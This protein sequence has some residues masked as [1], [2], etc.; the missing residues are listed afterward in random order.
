[1]SLIFLVQADLNEQQRERFVSSMNIRQIAMPQY[2]YLQV[3]QLFLELFAVS[4][5]GVAD[6]NITHRK[7]STFYVI[8]EGETE[9]GEYGF[10]VLDEETGEEGFTGLYTENEFWVLGAKG[11]Y[12]KRRIYGRSFKKG[13]PKGYGKKGGKRSRPGFRPRSKGKGYAAWEDDQQDTAFWGKGKGKGKKGKKGMKGKDSFEGMPSWKGKGKGDGKSKGGKPFQQQQPPQANIAQTTSS[14]ASQAP[15]KQETAHAEESWSYDYD[16]YWTR[17]WSG[18]ESYFGYDGDY[19]QGDWYNWSYFASTEELT[20]S[21][22]K[23]SESSDVISEDGQTAQINRFC[24][25]AFCLFRFL[26]HELVEAFAFVLLFVSLMYQC[27]ADL[28]RSLFKSI[29]HV[30][31][32]VSTESGDLHSFRQCTCPLNSVSAGECVFLNYDHGAQQAL[33]CEYVDLGS[34]PT[35]YVILDSGCTRAMGSRFAIDRLVQACQ[36]HPK[37]DHIWFSKQPC[38]SKF[39]F[40]NGEQSTVKERLAIHFRNDRAQTGWVTT[41][42]DIPDKGKVSIL[43]S[44]EQMRNLRMNIEHTPVGEFLMCPLFGMQRTAL[45]VS[46]SNHPVLDITAL[47]TSSWKPMYSFQSEDITCPGCNGKHRPHTNKEGCKK[48]KGSEHKSSAETG[49]V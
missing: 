12:S 34:H 13:K 21:E 15:E 5:T 39:S 3:K 45:A 44:V 7:R 38:S 41:C 17:D 8:E 43:F 1:M 20:E 26:G 47:A 37:R 29:R 25:S 27:F 48:F 22:D 36:Q 19:S 33:L 35:Y 16:T 49:Q 30:E 31:D 10:W 42:V 4:R 23:H 40:A 14:N 11:S 9:E 6:P 24:F 32:S 46:T 2:T 28:N 18:C